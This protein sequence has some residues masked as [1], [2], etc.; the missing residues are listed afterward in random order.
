MLVEWIP[1][2][3]APLAAVVRAGND[4]THTMF[5]TPDELQFQVGFVVYPEGSAVVPH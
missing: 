4:P 2:E 1:S 5:V 3:D